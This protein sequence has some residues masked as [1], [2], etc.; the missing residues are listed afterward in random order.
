MHR[1]QSADT[2]ARSLPHRNENEKPFRVPQIGL[3]V[4]RLAAFRCS[5]RLTGWP[6][7]S[8]TGRT[9]GGRV[10][11][12]HELWPRCSRRE[13]D[14]FFMTVPGSAAPGSG[15][16]EASRTGQVP[17]LWSDLLARRNALSF[18]RE[19][20]VELLHV[21]ASKYHARGGR[22]SVGRP[23]VGR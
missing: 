14:V 13:S 9:I 10:G 17:Y 15:T 12:L 16:G 20:V 8:V 21:D 5:R 23:G 19:D 11:R 6:V 2:G 3:G 22:R 7:K 1:A 18:R 4:Q